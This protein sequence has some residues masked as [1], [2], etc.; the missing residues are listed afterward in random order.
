MKS[1]EEIK[2]ELTLKM[3]SGSV[4]LYSDIASLPIEDSLRT[5]VC[6]LGCYNAHTYA[7]EV[8]KC[9]ND[10]TR[11]ASCKDPSCAFL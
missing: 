10:E 3:L 5:F 1:V 7:Y 8:D 2:I 9:P 6:S 4:I 11:A